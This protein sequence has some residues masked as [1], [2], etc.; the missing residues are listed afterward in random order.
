MF[1]SVIWQDT[2]TMGR[3]PLLGHLSFASLSWAPWCEGPT[4]GPAAPSFARQPHA[5]QAPM[6]CLQSSCIGECYP[7]MTN[8]SPY[9]PARS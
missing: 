9:M 4:R 5:S 7:A 2:E 8:G 1:S 6:L 3:C